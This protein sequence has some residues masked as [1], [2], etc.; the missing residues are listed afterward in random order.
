MRLI[1]LNRISRLS[2]ELLKVN[3]NVEALGVMRMIL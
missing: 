2:A 3:V 1:V